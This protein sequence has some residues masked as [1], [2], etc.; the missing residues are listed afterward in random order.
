MTV[1]HFYQDPAGSVGSISVPVGAVDGELFAEQI[2]L[3]TQNHPTAVRIDINDV[4]GS[5]T[6]SWKS[7]A[8]SDREEFNAIVR[9]KMVAL[10]VIK[11]SRLESLAS[12]L[13][14]IL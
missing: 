13:E 4:A 14:A 2:L 7:F 9:S 11:T 3:A 12:V 6:S 5:D 8:L 10:E 1:T